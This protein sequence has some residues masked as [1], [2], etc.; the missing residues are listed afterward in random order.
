MQALQELL[1]VIYTTV[2]KVDT[3]MDTSPH[4]EAMEELWKADCLKRR[5]SKTRCPL[6]CET[7]LH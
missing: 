1:F 3:A 7:V 2:R 4:A 5:F 6:N